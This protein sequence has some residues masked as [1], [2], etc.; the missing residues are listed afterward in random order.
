[1]TTELKAF[2]AT[3]TTATLFRTV[4]ING[5]V[6]AS[7][8]TSILTKYVSDL[9]R[10]GAIERAQKV[11]K[12]DTM[13]REASFFGERVSMTLLQYIQ[14]DDVDFNGEMDSHIGA[15]MVELA[16]LMRPESRKSFSCFL[17]SEEEL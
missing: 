10:E 4:M 13:I 6:E 1:M 5:I 11:D 8:G 15:I 14:N 3:H 7:S 9:R 12:A 2:T 17:E 16:K